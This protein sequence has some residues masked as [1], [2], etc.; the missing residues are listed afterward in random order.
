MPQKRVPVI[1]LKSS[2]R[3]I[4]QVPPYS[5]QQLRRFGADLSRLNRINPAFLV[6][7]HQLVQHALVN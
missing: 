1:S 3:T 5:A 7:I 6:V 2:K 4:S